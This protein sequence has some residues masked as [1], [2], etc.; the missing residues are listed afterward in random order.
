LDNIVPI[1]SPTPISF[2]PAQYIIWNGK[3]KHNLCGEFCITHIVEEKSIEEMLRKWQTI[4][5]T[6]FARIVDQNKPAGIDDLI[7][8]LKPYDYSATL[9]TKLWT[10][11]VL[12]RV[13]FTPGRIL[14]LLKN[15]YQIIIGVKIDRYMGE[16]QSNG[17]GHW[18]VI[19]DIAPTTVN[20]ALVTI[21]NPFANQL[22]HYSF[23]K[24]IK[25]VGG[26][27]GIAIQRNKQ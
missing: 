12:K 24:I 5:P 1:E 3:I 20:R 21:H 7:D 11:P 16:L 14:S 25:S 9:L 8:M 10:D 26:I 13:L 22:Q 17:I 6:I 18:V 23:N 19:K 4:S 2:D 27:H 15:N